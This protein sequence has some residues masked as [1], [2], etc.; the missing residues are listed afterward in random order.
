MLHCVQQE[1]F[2]SLYQCGPNIRMI[3]CH[4]WLLYHM[5]AVE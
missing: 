5:F 4:S 3:T 2:W 1:V